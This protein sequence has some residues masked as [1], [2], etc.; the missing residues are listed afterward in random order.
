LEKTWFFN[1]VNVEGRV[2]KTWAMR[3][4]DELKN[5]FKQCLAYIIMLSDV[6]VMRWLKDVTAAAHSKYPLTRPSAFSLQGI[7]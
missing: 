5:S 1:L 4:P 2:E 7:G 3:L 6:Q